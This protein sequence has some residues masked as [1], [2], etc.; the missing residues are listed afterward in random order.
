[1]THPLPFFELSFSAL[2][3]KSDTETEVVQFVHVV[4]QYAGFVG[5]IALV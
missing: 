2:E 4:S 3:R 5:A 1:M